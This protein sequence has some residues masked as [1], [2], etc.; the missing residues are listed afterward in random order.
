MHAHA[1]SQ[2]HRY[3]EG[4]CNQNQPAQKTI[5]LDSHLLIDHQSMFTASCQAD[6]H[7]VTSIYV[8]LNSYAAVKIMKLCNRNIV[9]SLV[10]RGQM[11]WS[12]A[13]W[14]DISE[15][16][17][18]VLQLKSR[19][20]AH[21]RKTRQTPCHSTVWLECRCWR[22]GVVLHEQMT[23]CLCPTGELQKK[24]QKQD[25]LANT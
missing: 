22:A 2:A 21:L 24:N 13:F 1:C 12:N 23:S 3:Q 18:F 8:Y 16:V 25:Y 9:I 20:K 11:L 5:I 14:K 15:A 19:H 17:T 7:W 10:R 4:G 6:F